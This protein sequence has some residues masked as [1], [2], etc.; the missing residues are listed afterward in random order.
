M[1]IKSIGSPG[2][3]TNDEVEPVLGPELS[4]QAE[5]VDPWLRVL[6]LCVGL[7]LLIG[8]DDTLL[9]D[10][11]IVE[12]LLSSGDDTLGEG[13]GRLAAAFSNVSHDG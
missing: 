4:H 6:P 10:E 11:E 2:T 12:G 7:A 1:E 9:P 13:V 3:E 8:N 5:G